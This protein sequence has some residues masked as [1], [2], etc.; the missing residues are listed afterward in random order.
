[1][2]SHYC[3]VR[4]RVHV[5]PLP[6]TVPGV[7][8]GPVPVVQHPPST[9]TTHRRMRHNAE[10]CS[11]R[12]P[13]RHFRRPDGPQAMPCTPQYG[14]RGAWGASVMRSAVHRVYCT[15]LCIVRSCVLYGCTLHGVCLLS[16]RAG[17]AWR[18]QTRPRGVYI[19]V[20]VLPVFERLFHWCLLIVHLFCN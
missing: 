1:M 16:A 14:I 10:R 15:E 6:S 12:R 9:G 2:C 5:H 18:S 4:G 7:T 17:C 13:P 20:C 8:R 11:V 19:R 3:I